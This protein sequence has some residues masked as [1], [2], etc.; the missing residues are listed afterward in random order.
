[1]LKAKIVNLINCG[2]NI[3]NNFV[4][5]R[6]THEKDILDTSL[7]KE[8]RITSFKNMMLIIESGKVPLFMTEF[9][10]I[11]CL[12]IEYELEKIRNLY[13]QDYPSRLSCTFASKNIAEFS[14]LPHFIE[15]AE[16]CRVVKCDMQIINFLRTYPSYLIFEL[17]KGYWEGKTL[18]E[19]INNPNALPP[20]WEYLIEGKHQIN[21]KG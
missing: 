2:E 11:N 8:D 18:R 14:T 4:L 13:Y 19:C 12:K 3:G 20:V 9:I 6:R 5:C 15:V 21:P 10:N 1:M 16:D 7:N 17:L